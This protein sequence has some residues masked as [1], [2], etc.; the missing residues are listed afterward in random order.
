MLVPVSKDEREAHSATEPSPTHIPLALAW[1]IALAWLPSSG[2]PVYPQAYTLLVIL[3]LR[4]RGPG[5]SLG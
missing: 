2:L 1:M 3:T 5:T 4:S